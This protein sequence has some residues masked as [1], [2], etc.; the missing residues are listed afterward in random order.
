M[1]VSV[2]VLVASLVL[3]PDLGA[4][5]ALGLAS[6]SSRRKFEF[7]QDDFPGFLLLERESPARAQQS[8][9]IERTAYN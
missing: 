5:F 4:R 6:S 8:A 2:L 1:L 7:A 9:A 3:R